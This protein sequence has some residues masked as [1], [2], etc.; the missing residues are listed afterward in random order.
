MSLGDDLSSCTVAEPCNDPIT[1]KAVAALAVDRNIPVVVAAGND[2][3]DACR[4]APASELMAYTVGSTSQS[5]SRSSFS[6]YGPCV[7]IFAPGSSIKSTWIGGTTKTNTISGTSMACPHVSGAFALLL[8]DQQFSN[9]QAAY[10]EMSSRATEN[11]V[12]DARNTVNKL[13]YVGPTA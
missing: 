13:L 2:N 11:A 8:G 7:D 1:K 12:N 3:T 10:D 6:N 9:V 4:G 5:D